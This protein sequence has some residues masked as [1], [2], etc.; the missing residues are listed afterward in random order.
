LGGVIKRIGPTL[1]T[2]SLDNL[3]DGFY[4]NDYFTGT[5]DYYS[6]TFT[7]DSPC[8][9]YI[10]KRST[11]GG[12]VG[13]Y[14]RY[15]QLFSS[16][17]GLIRWGRLHYEGGGRPGSGIP[18]HIVSG[19]TNLVELGNVE[20]V[21]NKVTTIDSTSDNTQYS[22]AKAVYDFVNSEVTSISSQEVAEIFTL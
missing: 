17:G 6:G 18:A 14:D 21:T 9:I 11:S 10:Y 8:F 1:N 20:S 19:T 22:G 5:Y 2:I 13:V 4:Y 3:Q 15:Y 12:E 7:V 16:K